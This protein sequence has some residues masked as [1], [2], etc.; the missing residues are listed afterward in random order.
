[1]SEQQPPTIKREFLI[2]RQGKP[3]ILYAG[4]LDLGHN[5]GLRRISTRLLQIP[6]ED[7]AQTAICSAEVETDRGTFSGI[8]DASPSNVARAMLT[9][10]IRLAETRAKARA[11]RDAVNIGVVAAEEM[12]DESYDEAQEAVAHP[13]PQPQRP[14]A[15]PPAPRAGVPTMPTAQ[16]S[17]NG[18]SASQ[19][20]VSAIYAIGATL[21]KD[22]DAMD[23]WIFQTYAREVGDLTRQEASQ[24]ITK[25]KEQQK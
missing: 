11:L 8:G 14:T 6:S 5:Q 17:S 21:K 9:S 15:P 10:T 13:R 24:V 4:L 2:E 1:M 23:E 22:R 3:F 12:G 19:A 7:N 16:P 18:N 25:L 20:Q